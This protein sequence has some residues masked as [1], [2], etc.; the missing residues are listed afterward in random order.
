MH[1]D[2]EIKRITHANL[3]SSCLFPEVPLCD[4]SPCENISARKGNANG[5]TA[6]VS[7]KLQHCQ[8]RDMLQF[9][10]DYCSI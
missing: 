6:D 4:N 10:R 8:P 9:I 5:E 1:T 3:S 7:R 2:A